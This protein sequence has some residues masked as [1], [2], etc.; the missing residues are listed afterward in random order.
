MKQANIPLLTLGESGMDSKY[1]KEYFVRAGVQPGYAGGLTLELANVGEIPIALEPGMLICQ[2]F[3]HQTTSTNRGAISQFK[4]SR[5]PGL[6]T[7]A[8]AAS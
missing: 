1:T 7:T 3:F 6:G 4:G 2:V 5:K 8:A